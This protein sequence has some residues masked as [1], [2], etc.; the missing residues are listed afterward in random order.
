MSQNRDLGHRGLFSPTQAKLGW[1]THFRNGAQALLSQVSKAR[2]GAPG[3][4][5]EKPATIYL[6]MI[7]GR[8]IGLVGGLGVGAAVHYYRRL[9]AAHAQRGAALNLVMAHAQS[10]E[11]L[12]LYAAGEVNALAEYLAGFIRSLAA[13]GAEFAVIPAITPHL[14]IDELEAISPLR[15]LSI[16][17]P[18]VEAVRK[19]KIGRAAAFGTRYTMETDLFGRLEGV[20]LVRP[21]A[22]EIE[23]IHGIYQQILDGRHNPAEAHR[24]L[25]EIAQTLIGRDGVE[26]IL[27]AGTDLAEVFNES[28]TTFP[29]VDCA[30][31]HISAIVEAALEGGGV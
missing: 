10:T 4:E 25:T 19:R 6:G 9:F 26:A 31:V 30:A 5:R 14:A 22:V 2:P 27:I 7:Q 16:F 24:R 21:R 15:V 3:G 11:A 28:N 8:S 1:G 17:P 18:L 23:E 13:A 12:R 20:E 29:H